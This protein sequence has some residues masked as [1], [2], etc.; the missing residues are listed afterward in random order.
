MPDQKTA[1]ERLIKK[2]VFYICCITGVH[3]RC[4]RPVSTTGDGLKSTAVDFSNWYSKAS[5]RDV[6]N[7]L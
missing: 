3:Y 2:E 4:L 1:G 5:G 7:L 6:S